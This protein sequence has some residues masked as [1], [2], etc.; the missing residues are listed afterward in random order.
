MSSASNDSVKIVVVGP[1]RS[2]KSSLCNYLSGYKEFSSEYRPTLGLRICECDREMQSLEKVSVEL[3]D[4]GGDRNFENGWPAITKDM[5]GCIIVYNASNT[6]HMKDL[7]FWYKAFIQGKVKEECCC[8]FAHCLSS[9][10]YSKENPIPKLPKSMTKLAA[11]LTNLDIPDK[12]KIFS[13]FDKV[14][15]AASKDQKENE[16]KMVLQ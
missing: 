4:I 1:K 15:Q 16:E 12:D 2:G 10:E 7:E 6:N 3:W 14:V 13:V 11:T 9:E 8:V 5:N